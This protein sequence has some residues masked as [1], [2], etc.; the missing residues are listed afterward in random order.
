MHSKGKITEAMPQVKHIVQFSGGKD[1]TCMLLMMLEK[2]MQVDEII[3]CDTGKEFP[4]MYK[5]ID[6]VRKYISKYGKD[7][8]ILKATYSFDYYMFH[9]EKNSGKNKGSTGYCWPRMWVR[10]CTR[11]LKQEPTK[12][13]LKDIGE[14]KLYLGIAAD[15]PKRHKNIPKNHIHPLFDWGITED[16]ALKYCYD[17][18]FDWSGLYEDFKRVSC[19]CCP[20]QTIKSL[21][22]L[23]HK[24]PQQWQELKS[25]D[26]KASFAF[27]PDY[28][29]QQLE[30]K[31]HREDNSKKMLINMFE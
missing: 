31:F 13:Y 17:H 30:E 15:E 7:I 26:E 28:S 22:V 6:Q 10:W 29:V 9:F 12:R 16:Q 14:H 1:S 3:M 23:Y 21:R 25:M 24:Y 8:T 20:L 11:I 19:W 27:R 18:G 5:H 2:G 4:Q